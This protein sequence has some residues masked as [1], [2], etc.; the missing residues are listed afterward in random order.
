MADLSAFQ[1]TEKWPPANPSVIQLYSFP[2]PNGVKASIA[3]EELGLSYEPHLVPLGDEY[4]RSDAFLSLNP[5]NKIPAM[6]DPNGPDGAPIGLWESGVVLTY[7]SEKTGRLGGMDTRNRWEVQTWLA[8][9]IAGLGPMF[10]QLGH[11]VKLAKEDVPYGKSRYI[12]EA[13]RLLSVLDTRLSDRDWVAGDYSIADIAIA[14]WVDALDF[15][16]AKEAVG[17]SDHRNVVTYLDRFYAR[18]AVQRGRTIPDP[19]G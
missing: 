7:L 19:N 11:F 2:T 3:L 13:K 6:I 8:W 17:W 16:E 15:Y 5:N 9:A 4:V 18:D 10:G 1:I 12:D 14:P